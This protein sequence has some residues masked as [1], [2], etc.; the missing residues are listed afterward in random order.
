VEG[1]SGVEERQRNLS[2]KLRDRD[3]QEMRDAEAETTTH[4]QHREKALGSV[5]RRV[6]IPTGQRPGDNGKS[7][8]Y[9]PGAFL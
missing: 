1:R 6:E 3:I 5:S 4:P 8:L 9:P 2:E 7:Y